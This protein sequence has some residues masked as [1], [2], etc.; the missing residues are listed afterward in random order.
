[1]LFSDFENDA[2]TTRTFLI[3]PKKQMSRF[4]LD[5]LEFVDR[6]QEFRDQIRFENN[7]LNESSIRNYFLV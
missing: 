7:H 4:H 2:V 5:E 6:P 3:S 1:M